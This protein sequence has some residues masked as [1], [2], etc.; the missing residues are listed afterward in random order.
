MKLD[1][2]ALL[3]EAWTLWRRDRALLIPVVGV[4]MFLPRLAFQLL[5]PVWQIPEGVTGEQAV[6]QLSQALADWTGRYGGWFVLTT[7]VGLW[8]ALTI[9]AL[10]LDRGR[11]TVIGALGRGLALLPRYLLAM[12]LVGLPTA[13]LFALALGLPL[14]FVVILAPIFYIYARMS[15]TGTVLVAE[16]PIGAIAS[17]GRSW[18]LTLGN[19][20]PLAWVLAGIM[21]ASMVFGSVLV[22]LGHLGES[23]PVAVG[24]T[25]AAA[26]A[27]ES[28]ATVATVLVAI[29]AYRRLTSKGT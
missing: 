24:I 8:G 21:L 14:L 4:T 6:R 18:R 26:V 22:T 20:W 27:V 13:G 9:I 16:S 10:Y 2:A 11:P 17:I 5:V 19:G 28:A 25:V 1:L 23:N 3:R 15:L 7:V 29:A 12:I